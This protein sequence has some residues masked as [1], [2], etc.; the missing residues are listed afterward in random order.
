MSVDGLS[1]AASGK[2]GLQ[3]LEF[4]M[5]FKVLP[6]YCLLLMSVNG[7]SNAASGKACF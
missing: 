6:N 1:N 7:S 2:A 5:F 4:V 3:G